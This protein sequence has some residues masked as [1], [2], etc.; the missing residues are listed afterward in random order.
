MAGAKLSDMPGGRHSLGPGRRVALRDFGYRSRKSRVEFAAYSAHLVLPRYFGRDEVSVPAAS[1]A[2]V[3]LTAPGSPRDVGRIRAQFPDRSIPYLHTASRRRSPTT[4]LLFAE[5]QPVPP[6]R[7]RAALD[8]SVRRSVEPPVGYRSS[9]R[10]PP[11]QVDGMLLR[12]DNPRWAADRFVAAGCL[13]GVHRGGGWYAD[14]RGTTAARH[15]PDPAWARPAI[16]RLDGLSRLLA[17]AVVSLAAAVAFVGGVPK[18]GSAALVLAIVLAMLCRVVA[19]RLYRRQPD[20][21]LRPDKPTHRIVPGPRDR[22]SATSRSCATES[23]ERLRR[24]AEPRL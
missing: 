23:P 2:V 11:R 9:R 16:D 12:A 18:W 4:L 17:L 10:K 22:V 13:R 20:P 21:Q 15:G 24:S 6:V 19:C 5:P 3:D 8:P 1:I 7:L 14:W